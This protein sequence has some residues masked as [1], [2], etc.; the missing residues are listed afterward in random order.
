M[1]A[2]L[3]NL[4]GIQRDTGQEF[5]CVPVVAAVD[6]NRHVILCQKYAKLPLGKLPPCSFLQVII[7]PQ[8]PVEIKDYSL[9]AHLNA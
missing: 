8:D 5:Q 3:I 9:V 4:P 2:E 1:I 7:P 6:F